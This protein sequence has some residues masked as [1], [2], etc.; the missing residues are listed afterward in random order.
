MQNVLVHYDFEQ[1]FV[2][3]STFVAS[4]QAAERAVRAI[5]EAYFGKRYSFELVVF[6]PEPGSLLQRIG[7]VLK[8]IT[9]TAATLWAFIQVLDSDFVRELSLEFLGEVP[10]GVVIR[11]FVR[12]Q[13]SFGQLKK[14]TCPHLKQGV[15]GCWK[16]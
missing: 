4:A 14:K 16:T 11:K 1:H 9:W 8:G 10:S 7:I 15:G 2:R 13:L 5:N 3:L 6:P 12:S